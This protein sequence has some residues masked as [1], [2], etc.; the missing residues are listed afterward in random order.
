MFKNLKLNSG[1]LD[2]DDLESLVKDERQFY[3]KNQYPSK[4]IKPG[5]IDIYL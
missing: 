3:R 4:K 5:K 1:K 2:I